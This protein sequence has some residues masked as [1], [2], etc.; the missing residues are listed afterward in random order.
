MQDNSS[1][2]YLKFPDQPQSATADGVAQDGNDATGV[3]VEIHERIAD[4][5]V[6]GFPS[7]GE[8]RIRLFEMNI[9]RIAI[10][11]QS[12]GQVIRGVEQP[13]IP[14]VGREQRQRT[15]RYE[16]IVMLSGAML[17]VSDLIGELEILAVDVPL[18]WPAF[19]GL[20]AH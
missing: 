20:P 3:L 12:H 13:G 15:N 16:A 11:R 19:D 17:D 8:P 18:A 7:D 14:S 1:Q 9:L 10:P 2:T 4:N 6:F 5:S